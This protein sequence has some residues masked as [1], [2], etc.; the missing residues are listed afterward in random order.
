M[1]ID[2]PFA[3]A[4][5]I[6][7]NPELHKI[8][9]SRTEHVSSSVPWNKGGT[10]SDLQM[11]SIHKRIKDG[12]HNL[13]VNR[14]KYARQRVENGSY[15]DVAKKTSAKQLENGTHPFLFIDVKKQQAKLLEEGKHHSQIVH[16][17]PHCGKTGKGNTMKRHH[18]YNC[19]SLQHS[20]SSD[21]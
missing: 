16:T 1:Y 2:D 18:F 13:I 7:P 3:R 4:L 5:G 12:T 20:N 11:E 19:K 15:S 14:M 9:Y 6:P 10:L 17:C 21:L 8:D